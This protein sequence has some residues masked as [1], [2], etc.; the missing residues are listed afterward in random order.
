[1]LKELN[2]TVLKFDTWRP[3]I[4]KNKLAKAT[5]TNWRTIGNLLDYLESAGLLKMRVNNVEDS[6]HPD[7]CP[8]CGRTK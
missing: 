5:G 6:E 8:V 7:W 4:N 2:E 3:F 1:M